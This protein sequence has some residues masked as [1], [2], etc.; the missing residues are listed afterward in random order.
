ML[1]KYGSGVVLALICCFVKNY[2]LAILTSVLGS[3][4][5]VYAIGFAAN[6]MKNLFD[7]FE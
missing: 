5:I 2:I 1:I 3:F 6:L 7:I 4:L